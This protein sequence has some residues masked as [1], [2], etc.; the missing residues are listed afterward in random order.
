MTRD[1]SGE[2]PLHR[3]LRWLPWLVLAVVVAVALAV[4]AGRHSS[5]RTVAQE[6]TAIAGEIRCPVCEGET[7]AES[8]TPESI[9]IRAE[10]HRELLA[11]EKP[12][13]VLDGLAA[14]YGSG[15][16]ERP[17]TRGVDLLLWVLPVVAVVLAAGGLAALFAFWGP[18][19]RAGVPSDADRALVSAAMSSSPAGGDGGGHDDGD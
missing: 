12:S 18:R 3:A 11:G 19:R 10:I 7:A 14:V 2:R 1:R 15:S 16:L 13:T 8:N 9:E 6:T 5:H 4:G 17:S